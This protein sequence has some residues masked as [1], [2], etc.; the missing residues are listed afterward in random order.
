VTTPRPVRQTY[1]DFLR[2]RWPSRTRVLSQ[3]AA[4]ATAVFMVLDWIVTRPQP[5]PPTLGTIAAFRLPWL[6]FPLAG[7][8]AQRRAPTARYLPALVVGLSVAWTWAS[9]MSYVALGLQ[10]SVLQATA[11]FSCLVITAILLPLTGRVRAGVFALMAVGHVTFDL[12]WHPAGDLAVRA[13]DDLVVLAFA[14]VQVWA[15]QTF[16]NAQR[17][18]LLLRRRLERTVAELAASRQR[19]AEAV[20]EVGHLAARVAHEV[21]NPLAAMKVN[22][23]WLGTDGPLPEHVSE[24]QEV[25]VE[26]LEAIGRIGAIVQDLRQR[27]AAAD[28]VILKEESTSTGDLPLRDDRD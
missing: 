23:R 4:S 9:V 19:A 27:A 28:E 17:R 18:G 16:A 20:S 7:W 22:V 6:V 2:S 12:L 24:R 1:L 15:V 25:V 11:L 21:N 13:A 14:V 3:Y 5:S 8:V 26:C 10:G